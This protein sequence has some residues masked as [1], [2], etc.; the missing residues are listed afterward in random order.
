MSPTNHVAWLQAPK[1]KL[2]VGTGPFPSPGPGEV[3]IKNLAL[4]LNPVESKIQQWAIFPIPYP[5]VLG[6]SFAGIIEGIADDVSDFHIGDRV[7]TSKPFTLGDPKYGPYQQ[8]VLAKTPF[9]SKLQDK[10][11]LEAAAATVSNLAT[12]VGALTVTMG[13]DKPSLSER[14]ASKGKKLLVYGGS[15]SVGGLAIQYATQA[16]YTVIT[17]SSPR[18]MD[19][20]NPLGAS[21]IINHTQSSDK[22]IEA[23]KAA[24]PYDYI[25]D[26]IALDSV[27]DII[28][29][30]LVSQGGGVYYN[31]NPGPPPKLPAG[32]ERVAQSYPTL[33]EEEANR[34]I[35]RW[36]LEE[37][38][39]LSLAEG[40]IIPTKVEKVPGGLAAIQKSLDKFAAG[41]VSGVK[42]VID[43][44]EAQ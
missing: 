33:L 19:T 8:Y 32:V 30:Y 11:S 4:A 7:V 40:K 29:H 41:T 3:L 5:G 20:V 16:G 17:T 1:A 13:L 25:F 14:A 35:Q 42:M 15:S 18:N 44:F 27:T 22:I 39:P 34:R 36:F 23:L 28:S 21:E 26:T 43:P 9:L 2:A 38:L 6:S 10:T 12:V 24:G 31:T 37:Y